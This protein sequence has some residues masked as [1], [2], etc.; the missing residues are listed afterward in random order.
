MIVYKT[1]IADSHIGNSRDIS[2][3]QMIMVETKGRGVDFVLNSLA[4]EKLQASIRCLAYGGK[5]LEIGKFDLAADNPMSLSI[6]AKEASFHGIMLDHLFNAPGNMKR[7]LSDGLWNIIR[8]GAVKPLTRTVFESNEI[9]EAFRFM[10]TGKH[11]GKVVIKIR[12]EEPEKIV[13]PPKMLVPAVPRY[14][15]THESSYII[16]GGLGGFGLE[17]ADWLILR[18]ARNVVL[19]SR[20]GITTGY[21]AL[22]IK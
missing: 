1:S 21:Q 20:K 2:F 7:K 16:T 9:E 14:V 5:F 6:F 3:E 19:T 22:R 4:E 17:L 12:D 10:A 13:I 11:M 18:G 15:C 8:D